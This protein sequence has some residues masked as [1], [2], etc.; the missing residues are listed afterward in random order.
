MINFFQRTPFILFITLITILFIFSLR[1]T[2]SKSIV[3]QENVEVLEHNLQDI[4]TRIETEKK[5]LEYTSSEFAKEGILRNELLLQKPGEYILQ[6]PLEEKET[7]KQTIS[8][9][10]TPWETWVNLLLKK[11]VN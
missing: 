11:E 4:S 1:R 9:E 2:A 8:R 7:K 10:I 3:S 5:E 6:I